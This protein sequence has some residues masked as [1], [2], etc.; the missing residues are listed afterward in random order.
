[1]GN[2][3]SKNRRRED[4][5]M[6]SLLFSW[7]AIFEDC[8]IIEQFKMGIEHSFSELQNN[9]SKLIKFLLINKEHSKCFGVDL[10]HGFIYFNQGLLETQELTE[11]KDSIRLIYFR[12]HQVLLNQSGKE[13]EH[14]MKYHLGFQ[15]NDKIGNNRQIVLEID[16]KG[17]FIIGV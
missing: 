15:W 8:S 9:Q 12:R 10:V 6:N 13:L 5:T 2:S 17:N 11:T 3:I 7:V 14:N 16:N 1:M 4:N